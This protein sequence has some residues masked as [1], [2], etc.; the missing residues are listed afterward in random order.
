[1]I[2]NLQGIVLVSYDSVRADVAYSEKFPG[3]EFLRRRG[4]SFTQC[5]ASAPITPVSHSSVM[6]GLQPARHGVRH[7]F[8]ERLDVSC[9]TL[10]SVLRD[11]GY[12]T[13][14]VVSCPGLNSWYD[15]G[16]GFSVYDDEIPLLPDGSDPLQTVDVKLRGCALKRADLVIERSLAMLPPTNGGRFFHFMHFFDAH[17]PYQP[18]SRPFAVNC[19]NEY[20]AEIA[21]LDFHFKQWLEQM[22]AT[23]RLDNT[24]VVLFGD[25]GEDLN[26]WYANDKGGP[27][28]GHPEESGHGC[29]LYEQTIRVPLIISHPSFELREIAEQVRLIDIMPTVLE[30]AGVRIPA[31]L[32][33]ISM[34][35]AVAAGAGLAPRV[36]Y[37]ETMYPREQVEAT[38]GAYEW[39]RDKKSV[40]IDGRYKVIFHLD[41]DRVEVYDLLNDPG[42]ANDLLAPGHRPRQA[43]MSNKT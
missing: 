32:D 25:H 1:V 41:D 8:R 36:A 33:G 10:A 22:D 16:R 20:E 13:S 37:S 11:A 24:L 4:V 26:G 34:A 30:L 29:L 12:D 7:L 31:G 40:R 9:E 39:T 2:D 43:M 38:N 35:H 5:V 15:I 3:I 19:A 27:E 42:E 23:G 28:L 21:Y 14:A 18:P 17:W 6:T